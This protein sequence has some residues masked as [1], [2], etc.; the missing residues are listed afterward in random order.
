MIIAFGPW[1]LILR[2]FTIIIILM[3]S[4]AYCFEFAPPNIYLSNLI[5][6]TAS[7]YTFS[8]ARKYDS[9]LATTP[10]DTQLVPAS[11]TFDVYFPS[12]YLAIA[13]SGGPVT[14]DLIIINEAIVNGPFTVVITGSAGAYVAKVSGAVPIDTAISTATI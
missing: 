1:A 13:S 6:N 14:C 8:I 7:D 10:W 2:K 12:D 4:T 3:L 11:S 9:N 5:I